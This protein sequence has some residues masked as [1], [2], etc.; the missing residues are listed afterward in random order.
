MKKLNNYLKESL[1]NKNTKLKEKPFMTEDDILKYIYIVWGLR[2]QD[3]YSNNDPSMKQ[4]KRIVK[5]W[6]KEENISSVSKSYYGGENT[7]KA[8]FN[9]LQEHIARYL[10]QK[11]ANT[12][13]Y[14]S[15]ISVNDVN[16]N[17]K[18]KH[19]EKLQR[20]E[21][22]I[23]YNENEISLITFDPYK[24]ARVIQV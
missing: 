4:L 5:K 13:K 2:E 12:F 17:S 9:S 8:Y 19:L 14:K 11:E 6:I 1:I 21:I 22:Y 7:N 15:G 20:Y 3:I 24:E 16:S 10:G 18:P 23:C